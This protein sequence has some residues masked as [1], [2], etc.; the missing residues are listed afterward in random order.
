MQLFPCISF[1]RR[2]SEA[3][4]GQSLPA[5]NRSSSLARS[6]SQETPKK[7]NQ[8][9]PVTMAETLLNFEQLRH[10]RI[11]Q[12][13]ASLH[14]PLFSTSRGSVR[15]SPIKESQLEEI[16][17]KEDQLESDLNLGNVK[18]KYELPKALIKDFHYPNDDE[19]NEGHL[20]DSKKANDS[21]ILTSR[22][23]LLHARFVQ[24]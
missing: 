24:L 1:R 18:P 13:P 9:T 14:K 15:D 5:L 3:P 12:S 4:T 23:R 6:Q 21:L 19:K 7:S 16:D 10:S 17:V 22:S 2:R 11:Q 8:E 20:D